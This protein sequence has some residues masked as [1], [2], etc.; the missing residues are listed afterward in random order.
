MLRKAIF[1][2]IALCAAAANAA[3]MRDI[4]YAPENGKFGL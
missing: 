1:L 3:V 4:P 2:A